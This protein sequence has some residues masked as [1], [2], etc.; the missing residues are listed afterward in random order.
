M[1]MINSISMLHEK[2]TD[3][4]IFICYARHDIHW[5]DKFLQF[6]KPI[7]RQQDL[8]LWSDK[9]VRIGEVW[10]NRIQ[11]KLE[12]AKA[13]VLFISPAF[14]ASDYIANE[15][16]PILLKKSKDNGVPIFQM[17]ISPCL[18]EE[19]QF[20][21]PDTKTGPDSFTLSSIQSANPHTQTLLE[22]TEAEQNRV[23]LRVARHILDFIDKK[24]G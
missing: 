18:Y 5:L 14:L 2:Q 23:M 17:I 9:E 20:L 15:E 11:S 21:Y 3:N 22:M 12:A 4:S 7:I 16:I 19:T 1:I 6:T 8:E 24:S 10:H 13:I